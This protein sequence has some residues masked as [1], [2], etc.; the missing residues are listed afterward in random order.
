MDRVESS[1][2]RE[3]DPDASDLQGRNLV[4]G[5]QMPMLSESESGSK[6]NSKEKTASSSRAKSNSS[7][8][9]N[10]S[11][12]AFKSYKDRYRLPA[13]IF[14]GKVSGPG[15]EEVKCSFKFTTS[16]SDTKPTSAT[17]SDIHSLDKTT[18]T[19]IRLHLI[20]SLQR[21]FLEGDPD[22]NFTP[23]L[24]PENIEALFELFN[25]GEQTESASD[26]ATI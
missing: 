7:S 21:F 20:S 17:S 18:L 8:S 6:V 19:P 13:S 4:K 25:F 3:I 23:R 2:S 14:G 22:L 9:E 24:S 10:E 16:S 15:K 1:E 11:A 12:A 5:N 26:L